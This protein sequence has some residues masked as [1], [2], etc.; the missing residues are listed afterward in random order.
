MPAVVTF[1]TPAL[2]PNLI[3]EVNTGLAEN[4]LSVL[5]IVSEWKDWL[6]ANAAVRLGLPQAFTVVG[7]E[8]KTA[9]TKLGEASFLHKEWKLRPAEYDH[10]LILTGD[11]QVLG[12]TG[13]LTVPTL[14]AFTVEV[15]LNTSTLLTNI[16]Q[17]AL[18]A[19]LAGITG[20]VVENKRP[21]LGGANGHRRVDP[22]GALEQDIPVKQIDADT[23]RLNEP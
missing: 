14:G 19:D 17:V 23:V 18:I 10:R 1:I 5:E 13:R 11:L 12:G 22:D 3:V 16:T 9:S 20:K 2:G 21:I 4:E 7:G 8:D 15:S 6:L